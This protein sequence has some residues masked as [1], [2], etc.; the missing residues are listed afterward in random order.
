[1][2]SEQEGPLPLVNG[3]SGMAAW[4]SCMEAEVTMAR[5]GSP[6]SFTST[7]SVKPF[8]VAVWYATRAAPTWCAETP[9]P[10]WRHTTGRWLRAP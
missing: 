2:R 8:Q 6:L 5:K 1:M 3:F 4:L 10:P 7:C 9:T